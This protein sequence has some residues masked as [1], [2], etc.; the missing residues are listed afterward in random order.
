MRHATQVAL[1]ERMLAHVE[2]GT[3]QLAETDATVPVDAYRSEARH[4]IEQRILFRRYPVA[5]GHASELASPGDFITHDATGVPIVAVRDREGRARAFVNACR[6][7]G[8]R[9]VTEPC[10]HH[11]KALVCP[12]HAWAYDLSGALLHVPQRAAFPSLVDEEAALVP[13]PVEIRHGLVWVRPGGGAAIDLASWLGPLDDDLAAFGLGTH[14]LHRRVSQ[15]REVNWKLVI[16][17]FLE[18]YHVRSLHR[19]TIFRFFIELG[20]VFDAFGPHVR[21]VGARRTIRDARATPQAEWDIRAYATP[22]YFVFPNTILVF[23]PDWVSHISMVPLAIDRALYTH[24]MLIPALPETDEDRSHW[25]RTFDLI[26]GQVFQREDL[27][28]ADSIQRTLG[29]GANEHFRIGRVE[30]PIRLFHDAM[31][32]AFTDGG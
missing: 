25:D 24:Q 8:T 14:T 23:H 3:T 2:A 5:V 32:R 27:A 16:E 10:G 4:Q 15:V 13:V 1:L 9:L 11:K 26:E 21:S 19:D 31:E 30:H 12:Y 28:I 7:R 29:S 18:G 22:F 17:A 6:H 20:T